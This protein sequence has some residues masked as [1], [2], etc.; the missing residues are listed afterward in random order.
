GIGCPK[1]RKLEANARKA[2]DELGIDAEVEKVQDI[3]KISTF[4][5]DEEKK[6]RVILQ[7][8]TRKSIIGT[9]VKTP[10]TVAKAAPEVTPNR[11]VATAIATSKWLL[12]AIIAVGAASS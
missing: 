4:G 7:S 1:C 11:V 9:S 10:I 3:K 2:I 8:F 12:P 6:P 5:V